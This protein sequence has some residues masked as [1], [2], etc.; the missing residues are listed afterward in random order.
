M[1]GPQAADSAAL[2]TLETQLLEEKTRIIWWG[3]STATG[4]C[5]YL[6]KS[7]L[8]QCH[9]AAEII[10]LVI[11][12]SIFNSLHWCHGQASVLG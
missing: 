9:H 2:M 10:L 12:G 7:N 6:E 5:D 8:C 3:V 1:Q 11:L 4:L